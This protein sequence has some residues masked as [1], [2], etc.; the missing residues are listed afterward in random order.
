MY[1]ICPYLSL[2][3]KRRVQLIRGLCCVLVHFINDNEEPQNIICVCVLLPLT[4]EA[5]ID[6]G[7]HC[8]GLIDTGNNWKV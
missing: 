2:T 7:R 3:S 6:Q 5:A 1:V 4:D 8:V